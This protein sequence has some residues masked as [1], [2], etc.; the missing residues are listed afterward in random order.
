MGNDKMWVVAEKNFEDFK[1]SHKF[2][3]FEPLQKRITLSLDYACYYSG[4]SWAIIGAQSP[5]SKKTV[6]KWEWVREIIEACDKAGIPVFLKNNL[7]LPKYSCEGG[8]PFYKLHPSGTMELRQELP[9]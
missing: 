4:I 3:S 7:R 6:P 9:Q 8:T 5:Y 1:A 2:I